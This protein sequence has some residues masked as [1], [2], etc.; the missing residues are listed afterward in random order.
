M[1]EE[2]LNKNDNQN[3]YLNYDGAWLD[4]ED[5][6]FI[7]PYIKELESLSGKEMFYPSINYIGEELK[8]LYAIKEPESNPYYCKPDYYLKR[9]VG[10]LSGDFNTYIDAVNYIL[11]YYLES[12]NKFYRCMVEN[13]LCND[14]GVFLTNL[15]NIDLHNINQFLRTPD[16]FTI[17]KKISIQN[18]IE[19]SEI[20][21]LK[22]TKIFKDAYNDNFI[23]KNLGELNNYFEDVIKI[24]LKFIIVPKNYIQ[25]K[26]EYAHEGLERTTRILN[27]SNNKIHEYDFVKY[28]E[29]RLNYLKVV[30]HNP[31]LITSKYMKLLFSNK[32]E[33][34]Y[35]DYNFNVFNY[36]SYPE[37][38]FD[39]WRNLLR[40][41]RMSERKY[42]QFM[43]RIKYEAF[44]RKKN[45]QEAS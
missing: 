43:F 20:E 8:K 2:N 27:N 28:S 15:F 10:F 39:I 23:K 6:E 13:F 42:H 38:N 24:L 9:I 5:F 44:E 30:M 37:Q 41:K 12:E 7:P 21:N 4:F 45:R 40:K 3:K 18:G 16:L 31:S 1:N 36:N 11:K 29:A 19:F 17:L 25:K 32:Y 33:N 14:S 34:I 26:L 35:F 22:I